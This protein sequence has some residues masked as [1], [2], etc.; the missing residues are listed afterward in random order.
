MIGLAISP[1]VVA[2]PGPENRHERRMR[3]LKS[4]RI[5]FNG[6]Y[7]VYDCRVRNVSGGGALLELPSLVG[8]PT[9][10]DIALDGRRYSCSVMWRTDRLMGVAFA[11]AKAADQAA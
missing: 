4:A 10:F 8:I 2:Q 9:R 1:S 3:V 11:P 5:E 6:G 7:S